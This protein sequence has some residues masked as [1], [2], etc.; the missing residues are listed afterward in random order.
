M[1]WRVSKLIEF[2]DS[3]TGSVDCNLDHLCRELRLE[4]SPAYAAQLFKRDT[5]FGVREYVKKRRLQQAMQH[6]TMTEL[7]IKVIADQL[8]YKQASDFTRFVREQR[9]V[10]PM[11]LRKRGC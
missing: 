1:D 8:G 9:H 4:I 11:K 10:N 6:L 3:H 7:P 2:I 5:G